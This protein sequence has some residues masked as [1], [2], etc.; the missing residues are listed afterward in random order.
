MEKE[1]LENKIE[2]LDAERRDALE[3]IA[4]LEKRLA[5]LEKSFTKETASAKSIGGHTNRLNNHADQIEALDERI[6]T[7]QSETKAELQNFEKGRK[8]QEKLFDQEQKGLNRVLDDFRKEIGKFQT[9]QKELN[10][11]GVET[12]AIDGKL[13]V[14]KESIQE[15]ISGEQR[16][17]QIASSLEESSKQDAKRL[18][19]MHGEVVALLTRLESA[20]KQTEGILLSQRKVEKRVDEVTLADAERQKEHDASLEKLAL[21]EANREHQWKAYDKRFTA[22]EQLAGEVAGRLKEFDNTELALKRAESSFNELVEKINRRVNELGEIQR[23][24]DQRFRQEWSTFQA[25]AQKRWSSFT[26]S[27]EEHLRETARQREKLA[28]QIAQLEDSMG[29]IQDTL[30]HLS[31]QSERSM[32]SLLEMARESLAEHERFVSNSR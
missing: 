27:H 22:I 4:S 21:A 8:Q 16:R 3:A 17:N 13:E 20:A 15:V 1:Q 30:Q 2:W 19:E 25:D 10:Q 24:G 5:S 23:L 31:D 28:D 6:N 26:L 14:L 11:R 7:L 32:Q 12:K 29:E 9:L 18:T